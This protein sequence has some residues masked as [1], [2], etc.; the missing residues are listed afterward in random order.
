M[1]TKICIDCRMWGDKFGGIGR[2]VKEIVVNMLDKNDWKFILL[3]SSEEIKDEISQMFST[4][5]FR[6]LSASIFSLK[7]QFLLWKSIPQCDVFWSP[8]MNVPFMPCKAKYRVV[9][10]HDVFHLANPQ[11]YSKVKRLLIKPYYYFSCKKSDLILTV[12]DFSKE[13]IKKYCGIESYDKTFRVYNGIDIEVTSV[14]PMNIGVDY[15]LFVGNIKPHKNIKNALLGFKL[16]HKT[17]LKFVI[18][19]KKDGFITADHEVMDIV[20][21]L[22]NTS[23]CVIFTGNISDEELYKWYKGAKFLI[24]PSFYEGFGLPIVEAMAFGLPVVCSDISVFKEI[25]GNLLNYFNPNSPKS[26]CDSMQIALNE[27]KKIYPTWISWSESAEVIT[28][29]FEQLMK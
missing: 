24:Q 25:G 23:E 15:V 20:E 8:Y 12:S 5:S 3:V 4:C 22:N 6:I 18:V 11:Y 7:E 16:L 10:L 17:N 9:T 28:E 14:K 19:G 26:V 21:D 27:S 1:I 2:Y 29:R 13:E